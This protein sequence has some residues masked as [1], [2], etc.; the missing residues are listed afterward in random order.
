MTAVQPLDAHPSDEASIQEY[1]WLPRFRLERAAVFLGIAAV[2]SGVLYGWAAHALEAG[3]GM[4]SAGIIPAIL[5]TVLLCTVLYGVFGAVFSAAAA[6]ILPKRTFTVMPEGFTYTLKGWF[7]AEAKDYLWPDVSLYE[8]EM[9]T[10][11]QLVLH[12]LSGGGAG[13]AGGLLMLIP[14]LLYMVVAPEKPAVRILTLEMV[15]GSK[16]KLHNFRGKT[17]SFDDF[18]ALHLPRLLPGKNRHEQRIRY[19]WKL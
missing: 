17:P 15:D 6:L 11:H 2:A 12:I 10:N 14:A 7:H 4:F 13:G 18:L 16:L 9:T 8:V 1:H 3:F 5:A 19:N